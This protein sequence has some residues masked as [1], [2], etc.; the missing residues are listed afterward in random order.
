MTCSLAFLGPPAAPLLARMRRTL[1]PV[2]LGVA[3]SGLRALARNAA[4]ARASVG[5]P[6][7]G[8]TQIDPYLIGQ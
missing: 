8:L 3:C 1:I 5:I 7:H 6:L 2:G 4:T